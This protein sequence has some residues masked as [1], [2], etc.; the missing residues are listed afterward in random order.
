MLKKFV[1][2][3]G[4]LILKELWDIKAVF[5]IGITFV[6][7]YLF[8]IVDRQFYHSSYSGVIQNFD[9]GVK[10]DPTVVI[11]DS[12]VYVGIAGKYLSPFIECGDSIVKEAH[13]YCIRLYKKK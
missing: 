12:S 13:S 3:I 11:N 4:L 8:I 6:F 7:F 1:H 10:E 9:I 2:N 5:L